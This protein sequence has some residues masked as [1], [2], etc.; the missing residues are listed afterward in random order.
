MA[1]IYQRRK[2]GTYYADY[3][4]IGGRR[5]KRSL[6]TRDRAVATARARAAELGT[7][8][9]PRR[10]AQTL[11]EAIDGMIASMHSRAEATKDMYRQK[12][13]RLLKS[14]G[15]PNVRAI[16]AAMLDRYILRR[17][18]VELEHGGASDHTIQK[19]LITVRRAL[20]WAVK[21]KTLEALPSWPEFSANYEPRKTWLTP[22]QFE[23]L[24]AELAQN[25][26]RW[27]SLAALA[28]MRAGE[29]ERTD[30][31]LH[32]DLAAGRVRVPGTKTTASKRKV[33]ILPALRARL[34]LVPEDK[35][36]GRVVEHWGN[37]RRDLRA[38]VEIANARAVSRADELGLATPEPMPYVSPNDLRRTFASWLVQHGADILT[39]SRMMGHTST[40]MLEK[41]YGQLTDENM[42][43]AIARI[44][45][46]KSETDVGPPPLALPVSDGDSRDDDAD[47][48]E[49][50]D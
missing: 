32:V 45:A 17:R 50:E 37:V 30:W 22:D 4:T 21:H 31:K 16:D 6:R 14:L 27:A 1:R 41:V 3:T 46:F 26:V 44:P 24:C 20:K 7:E 8:A 25:R 15:N 23:R 35:R 39:V 33:P 42:D 11:A 2:G 9:A 38:A 13:R 12:G 36:S 18:G 5:V 28:G 43:R 19:E 29:V 47:P 10:K 48:D 49:G 34:E 40:R